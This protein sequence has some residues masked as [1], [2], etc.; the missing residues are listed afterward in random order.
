MMRSACSSGPEGPLS[1]P[2]DIAAATRPPSC[3]C[4]SKL[5]PS[6]YELSASCTRPSPQTTIGSRA[7]SCAVPVAPSG[8]RAVVTSPSRSGPFGE[9]RTGEVFD[10]CQAYKL[11]QIVRVEVGPAELSAKVGLGVSTFGG[12]V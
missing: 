2:S 6:P 11:A 3:T 10:L 1:V 8:I 9:A 4:A 12:H 5:Q 7:V